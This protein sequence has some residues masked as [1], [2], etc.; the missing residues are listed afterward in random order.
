MFILASH[1]SHGIQ[2]V[3]QTLG[4]T[5][6]QNMA[7]IRKIS[8]GLAT[9]LFVGFSIVPLLILLNIISLPAGG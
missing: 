7:G 2:S 9:L 5:N 4:I 6:R 1:L 3:L 8:I